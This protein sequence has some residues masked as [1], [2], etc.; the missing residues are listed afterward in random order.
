MSW[1]YKSSEEREESGEPVL[2]DDQLGDVITFTG[3]LQIGNRP[4]SET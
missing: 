3:S 2:E 4:S 1:H